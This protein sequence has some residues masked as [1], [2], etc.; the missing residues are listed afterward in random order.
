[1]SRAKRANLP[2]IDWVAV[3][4][5]LR[6]LRGDRLTQVDF[7]ARIGI[8]QGYLSYLE[9]GEKEIGPAVLL[10]ISRKFGKSIEW[11]LTGDG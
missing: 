6:S 5:R 9:R 3:G 1:M 7:A 8:T 2:Q 10:S 4:E 11:L